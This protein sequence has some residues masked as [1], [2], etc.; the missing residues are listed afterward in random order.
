MIKKL[1]TVILAVIIIMVTPMVT[2]ADGTI[3]NT[4][5][6]NSHSLNYYSYSDYYESEPNNSISTADVLSGN[7]FVYGS[8]NNYDVDYYRFTISSNGIAIGFTL[9]AT[10]HEVLAMIE[11][12]NGNVVTSSDRS[13]SNGKYIGTI[14]TTLKSGTYYLVLFNSK[15]DKSSN[16]EFYLNVGSS[17]NGSSN[18]G[19]SSTSCTH[20][21]SNACDWSCNKCGEIRSTAHSYIGACDTTCNICGEKSYRSAHTYTSDCDTICDVCYETRSSQIAHTYTSDCDTRCDLCNIQ[22]HTLIAHTYS[23]ACD[24]SCNVCNFIRGVPHFYTNTC[25]EVCNE[26]GYVRTVL[27]HTYTNNCDAI[28]DICGYVRTPAEHKYSNTCDE[29]CNIC[30]ECRTELVHSYSNDCESKCINC[31]Y[32]RESLEIPHCYSSDCDSECNNCG[33]VREPIDDHIYSNGC[34]SH[35]NKCGEK[36]ETIIHTYDSGCDSKCNLCGAIQTTIKHTYDSSC[37]LKCNWCSKQRSTVKH[38]YEDCY[39]YY[40]EEIYG[41]WS[42]SVTKTGVYTFKP[43]NNYIDDFDIHSIIIF[44]KNNNRVIYNEEFDGFPLIKGQKYTISFRSNREEVIKGE[45]VWSAIEISSIIFPDTSAGGWYNNAVTYVVGAGI[46]GGYQNGKFGIAD[47]IQRQDFLVMLSRLDG[48]D[49]TTYGAKHSAFPDVPEDSY[50]EAA[51]NWGS[52][53]NIVTGYN[54]GKF[55]VGDKIT[56][57]QIVTF[58]YRYANHKGLDI[59]YTVTRENAI[60]KQYSDYKNVSGFAKDAV[61]WAIEKGIIN[62]K[63]ST[64]IV[65]QGNA[66]RCEVAKI[67]YNIFLNNIFNQ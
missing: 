63:T 40:T 2:F 8:L 1:S 4:N 23:N 26:C 53:K 15:A 51:V 16:Y 60:K 12:S 62:G 31:D 54:N 45:I 35:C 38:N 39:K 55:G 42:I 57:E 47:G 48:V 25:D 5:L 32:V 41:S 50:Y 61:L 18:N 27:Q 7:C 13:Y 66:Q 14:L 46:M 21:Y 20:E 56:R 28:C 10:G 29:S 34:D 52:E 64:N 37:D 3:S 19:G 6:N 11:D 9:T 24:T 22:R 33:W 67:M 65:P 44:D 36:R 30:G 58:L 43:N 59:N 49:L 17:N